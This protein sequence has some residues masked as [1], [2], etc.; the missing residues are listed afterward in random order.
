MKSMQTALLGN[1]ALRVSRLGL[2]TAEIGFAYGLG[3]PTVP[4]EDDTLALLR[5]AVGMGVTFFDTAN[6]YGLAEERIG[7]S[8]ILKNPG[9]VVCTKCAQFLEK[10]EYFEPAELERKIREQVESSLQHLAVEALPLLLLHGPSAKQMG[11]AVLLSVIEKLKTEGK[12]RFWGVSTRGVEAPLAAIE[13]GADVLE[14]AFS[15]ADRRMEP[16]FAAA[17]EKGVGVINRSVYLKG[18]F[19]GKAQYLPEVLEPL[20]KTVE[21]AGAIAHEL[22]MPLTELALRYTLSEPAIG[23]SLVGTATLPHLRSAAE[24]LARGPLPADVVEKLRSVALTDPEQV[25][26]ARW[27]QSAGGHGSQK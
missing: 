20:K 25:D 16:V 21:A 1:T 8:G 10:G 12:I 18:T 2:G 9:V 4:S 24:A 13:A 15:I 3:S 11:D 23:V 14:L 17:Q 5:E 27:P 7:K 26:P 22:N 6:Y 19:A